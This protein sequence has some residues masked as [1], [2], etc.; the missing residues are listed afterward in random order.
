M[1]RIQ[2][3]LRGPGWTPP[4]LESLAS[5]LLEF[6]DRFATSKTDLGACTTVVSEINIVPDT[7][8][9]GSRPYRI[10]RVLADQ[11]DAVIDPYLAAGLISNSLSP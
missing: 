9:V 11:F 5:V 4:V 7:K 10:N 2:F 8:L 1:R 3:D 6:A